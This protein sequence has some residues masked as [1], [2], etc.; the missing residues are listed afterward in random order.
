MNYLKQTKDFKT[1]F[2]DELDGSIDSENRIGFLKLLTQGN[3]LNDRQF[4]LLIS[5][6]EEVKGYVEQSIN[7]ID[8]QILINAN[9]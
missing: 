7:L 1:V 4:T 9:N 5:H 8:N 2:I 3:A 6:S